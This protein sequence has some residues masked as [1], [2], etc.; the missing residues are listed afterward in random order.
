M[1][2]NIGKIRRHA[3]D[4]MTGNAKDFISGYA[5]GVRAAAASSAMSPNHRATS[6]S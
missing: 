5:N 3:Y 4:P 1:E 2:G 6:G